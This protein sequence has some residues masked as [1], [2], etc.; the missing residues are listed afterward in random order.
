MPLE[1][2]EVMGFYAHFAEEAAETVRV[3]MI[4]PKAVSPL[5][6][7]QKPSV[8]SLSLQRTLLGRM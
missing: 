8:S 5:I 3:G 4:F 6:A 2:D 7:E 1:A